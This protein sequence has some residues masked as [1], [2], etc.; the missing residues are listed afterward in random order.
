MHHLTING[1][2]EHFHEISSLS[3][4]ACI[5]TCE[6]TKNVLRIL[7][8]KAVCVIDNQKH[9]TRSTNHHSRTAQLYCSMVQ[10]LQNCLL[11]PEQHKLCTHFVTQ[12]HMWILLTPEGKVHDHKFKRDTYLN[13]ER[14][15]RGK[16]HHRQ[17]HPWICSW[18][19]K[20]VA[21]FC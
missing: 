17:C 5:E 3:Y 18:G 6:F 1:S 12:C 19:K 11:G 15:L 9:H 7:Q 2:R 8:T 10:T 13:P 14:S 4:Y 16:I 21:H 20:L